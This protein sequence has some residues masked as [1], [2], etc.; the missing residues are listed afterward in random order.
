MGKWLVGQW[1]VDVI[2]FQKIYGLYASKHQIV[3]KKYIGCHKCDTW[4]ECEDRAL[5]IF[6]F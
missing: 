6:G 3:L 2:R 4:T 1:I 5:R